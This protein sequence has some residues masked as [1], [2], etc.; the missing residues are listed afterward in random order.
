[1]AK[2]KKELTK[3]ELDERKKKRILIRNRII[4]FLVIAVMVLAVCAQA[5][6]Q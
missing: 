4:G 3:R 2:E 5:F 6:N 1:M